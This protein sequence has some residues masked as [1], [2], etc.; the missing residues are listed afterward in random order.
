MSFEPVFEGA[1]VGGGEKVGGV[2]MFDRI[3]GG[4]F[5]YR[6]F[7]KRIYTNFDSNS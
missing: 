5:V 6:G 7:L 4:I 1:G 2:Q 3:F